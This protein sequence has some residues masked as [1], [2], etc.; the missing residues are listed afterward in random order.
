MQSASGDI[1]TETRAA[2]TIDT[3][4]SVGVESMQALGVSQQIGDQQG[5]G[6]KRSLQ[7]PLPVVCGQTQSL[8]IPASMVGI[9]VTQPPPAKILRYSEPLVTVPTYT[10]NGGG[11]SSADGCYNMPPEFPPYGGQSQTQHDQ[12]NSLQPLLPVF[13]VVSPH[14]NSYG[15]AL[16][17]ISESPKDTPER[18]FALGTGRFVV[19]KVFN[20]R[21]YV[22]IRQF[23]LR[24]GC[25]ATRNGINLNLSEWLQ[26][27]RHLADIRSAVN[28]VK[29]FARKDSAMRALQF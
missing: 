18:W 1:G 3:S 17:E 14:P 22:N 20:G 25:K 2:L 27:D 16:P 12:Q 6:E 13:G 29:A 19:V 24:V 5:A 8:L 11:A 28:Y 15:A 10:P 9:D 7:P 4:P 21:T 23:D 26:L